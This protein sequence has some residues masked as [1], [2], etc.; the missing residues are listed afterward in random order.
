M[1]ALDRTHDPRRRSW[2]ESANAGDAEFP[3]QNLPLGVFSRAGETPRG[4][5]AIGA[6]ILDLRAAAREGLFAGPALEAAD[7]ASGPALNRLM[8]LGASHWTALRRRLSDLLDAGGKDRKLA[9]GLAPRIL[10]A[11]ED[12]RMHLP[13]RIGGYTDFFASSYHA[14]NTGRMLRPDSPDPLLPNYRW[15]PIAYHGRASSIRPSG[16][17]VRRPLGQRKPGDG[18]PVYEPSRNLDYELELGAFIGPGNPLGEPIPVA[19]ASARVFGLCLL[20]D[21]SARDVQG[22]EYQPLGPFLAK[23]FATTISPWVVTADALAPFRAPALS[24]PAGDP[25]PL[26]HLFDEGDQR[27]GGFDIELE[28]LIVT[29]AMHKAGTAPHRLSLGNARDLYW[30][31][32]QMVAHHSSNG[33]NLEPGD[34][35]GSGTVSG[36]EPGSFGSMLELS[37]RGAKPIALASGE[38]RRFLEDGD[39]VILRAH[40]RREGCATIGFG[41]CRGR[42]AP[43]LKA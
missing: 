13:A 22:W 20:N 4:G 25:Q 3:I 7:A 14:A 39:E 37:W 31:L 28:A 33:C 42:I 15:M 27:A 9:E 29:A 6:T 40:A 10:V 12:A 24:R 38:T 2:V 43:A 18:P 30:T 41:E 23:N 34:L 32:A 17:P 36:P 11:I 5:V 35:F 8:A 19:E 26:P 16:A 21:W 1:A